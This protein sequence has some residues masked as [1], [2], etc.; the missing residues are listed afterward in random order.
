MMIPLIAYGVLLDVQEM[1]VLTVRMM[2]E[3]SPLAS[4]VNLEAWRDRFKKATN[5]YIH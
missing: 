3:F 2:V 5:S 4:K 1:I